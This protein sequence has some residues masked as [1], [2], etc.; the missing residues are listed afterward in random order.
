[1]SV[2]AVPFKKKNDHIANSG[3]G[4]YKNWLYFT[5]PDPHLV[6]LDAKDGTVRWI[7]FFSSRRLHTSLQ[8]DW[9]SDV[10]SSDLGPHPGSTWRVSDAGY[11]AAAGLLPHA[12]P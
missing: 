7:F 5:T 2:L 6:R 12:W 1:M 8:G 9:S 4:M 10:C 3:L 11:D